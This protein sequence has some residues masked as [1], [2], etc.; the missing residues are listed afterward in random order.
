MTDRDPI[1]PDPTCPLCAS[2]SDVERHRHGYL[3][4]ACWT[5]FTG[6]PDEWSRMREVREMR[7]RGYAAAQ[8]E[9]A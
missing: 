6:S 9:S 1:T 4:G 5:V 8:G 7:A 2:N 3:C